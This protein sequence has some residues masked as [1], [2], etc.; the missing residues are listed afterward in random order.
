MLV[1]APLAEFCTLMV[2]EIYGELPS[3]IYA[4]LLMRG[5][6]TIQQLA[7][8]T[9][10]NPRQL[11]HGLALLLQ[12]NLLYYHLDTS[13][14]QYF[15][16]ANVENAYNLTRTGKILE[17]VE[18]SYGAAAKDIM[19]TIILTGQTRVGDLVDAYQK[20]IDRVNRV[21][22]ALMTEDP[23]GNGTDSH[24]LNSDISPETKPEPTSPSK[25]PDLLISS[26][27][28]L[29]SIICRL[30]DAELLNAVHK[31]TYESPEDLLATVESDIT[32]TYP[33]GEVKGNKAKAEYKD[34]VA[35]ALRNHRNESKSLKRKLE[36]NGLSA[37]RRK[38]YDGAASANGTPDGE[39]DL[40]ID[41]NQV[42]CLN[43]E[44]C[45]VELRNRRLMQFSAD[46]F[47][48]TT[49]WVY[50]SLLKLLSKEIS[51]CRDDPIIDHYEK[52]E[53]RPAPAVVTTAQILDALRTSL[54]LSSGLGKVDAGQISA[55]AAEKITEQ[56]PRKKFFIDAQAEVDGDA[57]SD[58]DD[59]EE[60]VKPVVDLNYR[61][62]AINGVNGVNGTHVTNG[63][64]GKVKIE[65]GERRVDR[66]TQL[67]QHLLLLSESTQGFLRHC[68]VDEWTVDFEPLMGAL[69]QVEL[70]SA[71]ENTAGREGIRLVRMLRAKGKLDEKA[72]MS[73]ALMRKADMSKKLAEMHKSGF[74]QTQEVPREAKAD[75]KKSFFLWYFDPDMTLERVLDV[76]YKTM[77]HS[78]QVLDMLREKDH[79]ILSL[80][81]RTDVKGQEDDK[82]RKTYMEK[83][84]R[85]L[86][87]ER[88]LLAQIQRVDDLVAVLRD[89]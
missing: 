84:S 60:D 40:G 14:P 20:R 45:L 43:Y 7:G 34:K 78:L 74:V 68:G 83:L 70:D 53:E 46:V 44:K 48:T 36:Q 52:D 82:L 16:E 38:L 79:L 54:D 72:I 24:E 37:K 23:F 80:V 27:A 15:Y 63:V 85:F 51:R 3:R 4:S 13:S 61:P 32:R 55:A 81:K 21:K 71:I 77:I 18:E 26:T 67:R 19:Q 86:K 8:D 89:Y 76:A 10:M 62:T 2:D 41:L 47:G 56:A 1:T 33:G 39:M 75:V 50:G 65:G 22:E 6:S 28:Q 5:R 58:E 59:D 30:V 11:R 88:T 87:L 17:M 64:N 49:S 35:E 9:G 57:S 29:K 25:K 73:V 69:R 12:H 66:R 42:I 31:T